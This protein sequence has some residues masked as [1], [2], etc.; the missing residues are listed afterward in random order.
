MSVGDKILNSLIAIPKALYNVLVKP[1]VDAIDFVWEYIKSNFSWAKI[2]SNFIEG[3]KKVGAV[4]ITAIVEGLKSGAKFAIDALM[5]PFKVVVGAASL[6]FSSNGKIGNSIIEGIKGVAGFILDLLTWPFRTAVNFIS[7]LFG[8]D[9]QLGTIIVEGI[10]KISS[11]IYD[12]IVAPFKTAI[13]FIKNS[14]PSMGK[15]FGVDDVSKKIAPDAAVTPQT[16]SIVEVQYLSELQ[17]VV[18]ELVEAIAKLGTTTTSPQ[19]T[20]GTNI[21][22]SALESK[23]DNL[24]NLLVGGAVRVYLDG[25]DVSSAMTGIGR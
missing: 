16:D 10:K 20:T 15:L 12:I 8:G 5:F 9:G 2:L 11:F 6:M 7:E 22:T 19:T 3:T 18:G 4:M 14:F 1:F 25:K 13:D 23:L 24:T 21:N 17:E